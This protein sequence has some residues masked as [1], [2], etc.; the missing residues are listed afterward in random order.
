[1]SDRL[2]LCARI[3][4]A[5]VLSFSSVAFA[6]D[7]EPPEPREPPLPAEIIVW[8][9]RTEGF[10]RFRIEAGEG[11]DLAPDVASL[12]KRVPGGDVNANGALT[13]LVQYRGLSSQRLNVRV[14][15]M[16]ISPGGANW[17]DPPLHYIP[18]PWLDS[19]EMR[20]GI[21]PVSSGFETLG[22]T[23]EAHS[24]TSRFGEGDAWEIHGDVSASGRTADDS[25][26]GGGLLWVGTRN[27]R[28]H[29]LGAQESGDDLEFGSGD[30]VPME[31]ERTSSGAGFGALL[32]DH[33]LGFDYSHH[34]TG[35]AG[36]PALPMD[37]RWVKT[38]LW[39]GEYEATLDG[40]DLVAELYYSDAD[41]RMDNLN[42]RTPP[43]MARWADT[44]G[45]GLGYALSG[46]FDLIGGALTLGSD[47]HLGEHNMDVYDPNNPMFFVV[48]FNDAERDL[49]G[50]FA[51]WQRSFAEGWSAEVGVRYNHVDM[52]AGD[53][54][55]A[56]G[57]PPPAQG[58]KDAFNAADRDVKDGNVDWVAV[59]GYD[60]S[61]QLHMELGA[62]RKMRSPSY[63]ERY[64]WLPLE[65]TAGLADG[66][67]YVGDIDLDPEVSH[68]VELGADWRS[69]RIL[70]A[71]RVFYRWVDDYIQGTPFD[72]TPGVIDS[73]TEM[74]SSL[75]GDPTPLQWTNVDA[76]LYGFDLAWGLALPARL[77]LDGTLS[78][79][80]GR[81]RDITDRLYRNAPFTGTVALTYAEE[82]WSVTAESVFADRQ[83]KVSDTN[84][85]SKTS[86][87]GIANLYGYLE[88]R[89]GVMLRA[90][91][92]NV[93]D[94]TYREHLNGFNRITD[95]PDIAPG[96]RLPGAGRNFVVDVNYAF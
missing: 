63:L 16:H 89:E 34:R 61:E 20:R 68:E 17:M 76:K 2:S 66:N 3:A 93:F 95:N 11:A 40:V 54:D 24:K 65:V 75:N 56:A 91:V 27:F 69:E 4:L 13:G 73:P 38:N 10:E 88:L 85:E 49:Y 59:L 42:L 25:L 82:R 60:L 79:V 23:V 14:N 5:S 22:G 33:E 62:A 64:S 80:R 6:A 36:T 77:R 55:L 18:R 41:H 53:V 7:N 87:Y 35:E 32:G 81:R 43:M 96:E 26:A 83:N 58:L 19:I 67:N 29:V 70:F 72:A 74:V 90:G 86:G 21:A 51:E 44:D 9:E 78:Y 12:M 84:G 57:L 71:P 94:K 39:R 8:G 31:Y 1:M 50:V 48:N 92:E 15:G 30:I 46:T 37:I 52:D 45:D 28:A 47:A